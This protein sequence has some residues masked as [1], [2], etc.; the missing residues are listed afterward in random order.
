MSG[1][2]NRSKAICSSSSRHFTRHGRQLDKAGG[3]YHAVA[4]EG[5]PFRDIAQ[6]IGDRLNVPVVGKS[7]V[8]A[9]KHFG[10][11]APFIGINNPVSGARTR[12]ILGWKP[13]RPSLFADLK[14]RTLV[15]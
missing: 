3:T 9:T 10:F 7:P 11:L 8:L 6:V 13:G 5:I 1:N 14:Q 2:G 15:E 12:E 4:E